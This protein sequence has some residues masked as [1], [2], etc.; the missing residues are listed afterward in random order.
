M[1]DLSCEVEEG[2]VGWEEVSWELSYEEDLGAEA[3]GVGR[4][5]RSTMNISGDSEQEIIRLNTQPR[6]L[7]YAITITPHEP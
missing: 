4:R 1:S 6:I 3:V 2:V 5:G 7:Q